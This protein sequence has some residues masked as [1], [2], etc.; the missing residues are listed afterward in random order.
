MVLGQFEIHPHA[1][2]HATDEHCRAAPAGKHLP[3]DSER[4][5]VNAYVPTRQARR[6]AY[7]KIVSGGYVRT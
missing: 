3:K 4:R 2:R 6:S 1:P 7:L 5:P